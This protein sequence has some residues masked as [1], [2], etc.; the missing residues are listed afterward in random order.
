M[1]CGGA[2]RGSRSSARSARLIHRGHL[3]RGSILQVQ[4]ALRIRV[5]GP[6]DQIKGIFHSFTGA[7]GV[8]TR[9]ARLLKYSR[10][11]AH[12]SMQHMC[13]TRARPPTP[14]IKP[15]G[16]FA[17]SANIL[18]GRPS[19]KLRTRACLGSDARVPFKLQ[20]RNSFYCPRAPRVGLKVN[21]FNFVKY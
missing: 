16:C 20:N 14:H 1:T 7:E 17:V 3:H 9:A 10:S 12:A 8:S 18:L 5:L 13:Y 6:F 4:F 21:D 19:D 15:L 2:S 11:C